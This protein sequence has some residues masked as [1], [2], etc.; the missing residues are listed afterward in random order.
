VCGL[1]AVSGGNQHPDRRADRQGKHGATPLINPDGGATKRDALIG[2]V[3]YRATYLESASQPA[4]NQGFRTSVRLRAPL[5]GWPLSPCGHGKH[6][7]YRCPFP[8]S[9]QAMPPGGI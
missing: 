8:A 4:L 1:L 6:G 9:E 3:D 2:T 5:C 7:P